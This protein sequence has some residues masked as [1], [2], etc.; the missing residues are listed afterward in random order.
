VGGRDAGRWLPPPRGTSFLEIFY[1][2][3]LF[4][5]MILYYY[6]NPYI[7]FFEGVRGV[8]RVL[9]IMCGIGLGRAGV[10]GDAGWRW[11]NLVKYI[12]N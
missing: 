4:E 6:I 7:G 2:I 9:F 11:S 5:P 1:S 12:G 8:Y 10:L 3:T